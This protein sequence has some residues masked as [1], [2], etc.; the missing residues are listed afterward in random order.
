VASIIF[1]LFPL[2][3]PAAGVGR[4]QGAGLTGDCCRRP[5]TDLSPG[6]LLEALVLSGPSFGRRVW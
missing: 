6:K 5:I 2:L 1:G 4:L 3:A